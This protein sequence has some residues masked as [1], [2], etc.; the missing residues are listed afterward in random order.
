[1]GDAVPELDGVKEEVDVGEGDVVAVVVDDSVTDGVT[2]RDGVG[3][4]VGVGVAEGASAV[5]GGSVARMAIAICT[6]PAL[7]ATIF[8]RDGGI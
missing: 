8:T 4:G 2:V 7:T 1:M 6:L 5:V 3:D